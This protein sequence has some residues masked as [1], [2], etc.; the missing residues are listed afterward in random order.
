MYTDR[1]VEVSS[2]ADSTSEMSPHLRF[3]RLAEAVKDL[4]AARSYDDIVTVSRVAARQIT[5]AMGVAIVL[6]RGEECHYIAE[7]SAVPL[8]SGQTF[9]IGA[10][11]S[12]WA[13]AH[14]QQV[15]IPDIYLDDR[16]PHE[17]YRP[18][19]IHSLIMTPVGEPEPFAALGAYWRAVR[20]A[21]PEELSVLSALASCMATALENMQL[22]ASLRAEA[23]H[24]QLLVNE[25][26][27]RV[28][29]TVAIIQGLA[30]LTLRRDR[31]LRTAGADFESRL[32]SL[33]NAHALT[34]DAG[35]RPVKLDELTDRIVRPFSGGEP[36]RFML[37]GPP[38]ALPPKA[39]VA[40]AL[41]VHELCANAAK[42]GA[43]ST[44]EGRVVIAWASSKEGVSVEWREQGG[45]PV[46]EPERRGFGTRMLERA[47]ASE[48][49]GTVRM[50][51]EPHGLVCRIVAPLPLEEPGLFPLPGSARSGA[52]PPASASVDEQTEQALAWRGKPQGPP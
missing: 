44:R 2:E 42:Y 5:G 36:H 3:A 37:R 40:Y 31:D 12:G 46:R 27:H 18:V 49:D 10:C 20:T 19:G 28:K 32:I 9:P 11:I 22:V 51:F 48:L 16:I 33:A 21:S 23:D 4:A 43:L 13:M 50:H 1:D 39:A 45:P 38:I 24:Q 34:A 14:R 41:A 35:W 30:A 6:R 29:N 15:A 8:W 52:A 7:D 26:N 17:A 47:L 25:L